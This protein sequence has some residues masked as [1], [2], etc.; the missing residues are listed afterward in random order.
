LRSIGKNKLN[1]RTRGLEERILLA[2]VFSVS[3]ALIIVTFTALAQYS[4]LLILTLVPVAIISALAG[5]FY[6]RKALQN[7]FFGVANIIEGLRQGDFTMRPNASQKDG[8]W[9]EVNQELGLLATH[10]HKSRVE[11]VESEIILDKLTEEF[12]VPLL[13]TDRSGAL[14]H[15]NNAGV[16]LFLIDRQQLLGL[17]VLQLNIAPLFNVETGVVVE[18]SF[19]AKEARWEVRRSI[20]HQ[21]G[22]RLD[23][24]LLNDLSRTLREEERQAWQ[25]LIRVLGHELNNSLASITSVAETM[26]NHS[27]VMEDKVLKKGLE[28][29][30]GRSHGLQRFTEAYTSLAKLPP[31]NKLYIELQDLLNRTVGL[32]DERVS[33]VKHIS[34]KLHIDVDQIEQ[35]LIN[36]IKNALE[37]G[38][39]QPNVCIN[40]FQESGRIVITI[41]DNGHGIAN[42]DNLFVPFYTT[43]DE[44]SGIGLYLCRQIVEAHQGKVQLMNR[45]D[46]VG[47]KVT[48]WLP[49][50]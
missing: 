46:Q 36:L 9:G 20:I 28:V 30:T 16:S 48:L 50:N 19:P 7:Q 43:K 35:V 31:P 44:G 47:C 39:T 32:F 12:D 26:S 27:V 42:Q 23:V 25:K 17:S 24:L 2:F 14:R 5:L 49:I 29:I 3:P 4:W 41:A 45:E 38:N 34:V 8:A 18:H 40:A 13:M 33:L 15:I 1:S 37:S 11:I 21:H 6:I 10:L 22:V